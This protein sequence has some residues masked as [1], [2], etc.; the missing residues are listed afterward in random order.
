MSY[1]VLIEDDGRFTI[2]VHVPVETLD[3]AAADR[4][5]DAMVPILSNLE[6]AAGQELP[7]G[8]GEDGAGEDG[9]GEIS[10]PVPPLPSG[11]RDAPRST[12]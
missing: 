1:T 12:R 3:E 9:E 11:F 4:L 10:P 2:S 7:A 8:A 5:L 6:R